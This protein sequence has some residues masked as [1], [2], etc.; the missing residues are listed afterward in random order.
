MGDAGDA[1]TTFLWTD[2]AG[3]G[4]AVTAADRAAALVDIDVNAERYFTAEDRTVDIGP[5]GRVLGERD[6]VV[7]VGGLH[8]ELDIVATGILRFRAGGNPEL[9]RAVEAMPSTLRQR[10]EA[11]RQERA[12]REEAARRKA[13]AATVLRSG[14]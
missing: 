9:R 7:Q 10:N 8:I 1:M 2:S 14:E 4:G 11:A 5:F 6:I 13:R 12:A 3:G